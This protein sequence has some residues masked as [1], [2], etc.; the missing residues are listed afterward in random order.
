MQKMSSNFIVKIQAKI[1]DNIQ[2]SRA[3]KLIDNEFKSYTP[4]KKPKL[5]AKIISHIRHRRPPRILSFVQGL[6]SRTVGV[7]YVF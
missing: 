1:T 2:K 7:C 4:A 6:D 3:R 5:S